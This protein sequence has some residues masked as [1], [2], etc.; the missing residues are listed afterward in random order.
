MR[1]VNWLNQNQAVV[2]ATLTFVYVVATIV[3]AG[4][5][6]QTAR[7]AQKNLDVALQLE[8]NRLRPYVVFK[9]SSSTI[10]RYTYA[11]IKNRG[12]SAAYNVKVSIKPTLVHH[13]DGQSPLTHYEILFLP[14]DEEITDAIDSSPAFHE[15]YPEPVFEG[16]V[17]YDDLAGNKYTE[18]FRIDLTFLKKR[19]YISEASVGDELKRLNETV[20]LIAKHLEADD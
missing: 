20:T 11:S 14:P 5:S 9:I 10:R 2:M 7:L 16:D 8:R 6:I 19:M 18:P 13:Y 3:I 15:K 12:L 17:Q 1:F 4:L